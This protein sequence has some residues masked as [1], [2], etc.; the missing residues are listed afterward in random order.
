MEQEHHETSVSCP[1][2][3]HPSCM[4]LLWAFCWF[5]QPGLPYVS[6]NHAFDWGQVP[7]KGYACPYRLE[8]LVLQMNQIVYIFYICLVLAS[9]QSNP[10]QTRSPFGWIFMDFALMRLESVPWASWWCMLFTMGWSPIVCI[11]LCSIIVFR[12]FTVSQKMII[13]CVHYI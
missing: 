5:A 9:H 1:H 2:D 8:A 7:L 13:T 6:I 10:M 11:K 12:V 4:V 3:F